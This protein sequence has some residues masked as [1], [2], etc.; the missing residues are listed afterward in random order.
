MRVMADRMAAVE[1]ALAR[2]GE[3]PRMIPRPAGRN[4]ARIREFDERAG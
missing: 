4:P 1:C 3:R 2:R